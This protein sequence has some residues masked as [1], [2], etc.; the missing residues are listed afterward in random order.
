MYVIMIYIRRSK[1]KE[2]IIMAEKQKRIS[3][4]R[5]G[6]YL[7]VMMIVSTVAQMMIATMV[8]SISKKLVE[9]NF[10]AFAITFGS[11]YLIGVPVADNVLKKKIVLTKEKR[12]M[13]LKQWIKYIPVTV[14]FVYIGSFAGEAITSFI[15]MLVG[16][17][18]ED[19]VVAILSGSD[20]FVSLIFVGII[21]PIVE[22]YIFRKQI[23]NHTRMYGE[24]RAVIFSAF[25]FALFHGNLSQ[26][27]YA[28]TLGLV[29]GYVYIKTDDIK[30]SAGLHMFVNIISGV[31]IG[32]VMD[33]VDLNVLDK[34]AASIM[35]SP[36]LAKYVVFIIYLVIMIGLA[37]TGVIIV[38]RNSKDITFNEPNIKLEKPFRTM[39]LNTGVIIFIWCMIVSTVGTFLEI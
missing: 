21:G 27:F 29:F 1:R 2:K 38:Y 19:P 37:I 9:N 3:F 23:I 31:L 17:T 10:V 22:E 5:I 24:K 33:G 13:S 8:G 16:K 26:M 18:P 36:D 11:M 20:I 12:P 39:Y 14:L 30:Y 15:S 6:Y 35:N 28:F 7:I 32:S 25:V 4:S 34:G